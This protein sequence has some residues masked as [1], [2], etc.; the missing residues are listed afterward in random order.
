LILAL[1]LL[2]PAAFVLN[3]WWMRFVLHL[4]A[5]WFGP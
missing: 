2:M 1:V 3:V 4:G 5:E